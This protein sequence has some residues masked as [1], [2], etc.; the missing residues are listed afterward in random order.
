MAGMRQRNLT[1]LAVRFGHPTGRDHKIIANTGKS[2]L[3]P[4]YVPRH[5]RASLSQEQRNYIKALELYQRDKALAFT[6][7]DLA[8]LEA[9]APY[10]KSWPLDG[11][12]DD[13]IDF[14]TLKTIPI[15]PLYAKSKW[16]RTRLN[17]IGKIPLGSHKSGYFEVCRNPPLQINGYTL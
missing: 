2:G 4:V 8:D 11:R 9:F 13:G 12:E 3:T 14:E 1:E 16:D 7:Q 6:I 17:N 10:Y 5:I 15:H